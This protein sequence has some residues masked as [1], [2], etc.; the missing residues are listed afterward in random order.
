MLGVMMRS[1]RRGKL[2]FVLAA[3]LIVGLGLAL[4]TGTGS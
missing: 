2:T 1:P 3:L 4:V